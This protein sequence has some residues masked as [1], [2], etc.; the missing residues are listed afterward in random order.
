MRLYEY[1]GKRMFEKAGITV[2]KGQ[3]IEREDSLDDLRVSFPV[4]VKAQVLQGGRGKAGLIKAATNIE[5]LQKESGEI[6]SRIGEREVILLEEQMKPDSEAYIGI[7]VNDVE[8]FSY[9]IISRTG[10]MDIEQIAKES[11]EKIVKLRLP[12]EGEFKY[13]E[14]LKAV[15]KAGFEGKLLPQ[16]ADI[17]YNLYRMY[18]DYELD[19]IEINPLLIV[20]DKVVAGDSKVITDDYVIEKYEEFNR[21]HQSRDQVE[22]ATKAIYVPLEGGS[23]GIISYGASSTMMTV[24][25]IAAMG[26]FPANFSD[27]AGGANAQNIYELSKLI[28]E[29]SDANPEV[30]VVLITLTLVAHSMKLSVDAI[31]KAVNEVKPKNLK[32]VA[33]VRAA[34]AAKKEMDVE[35]AKAAFTEAGI[36]WCDTLGDAIKTCIEEAK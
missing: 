11:P 12:V 2:P 36:L 33:N 17:A 35:G 15:K 16:A 28:L 26:G 7:A 22:A 6:F 10:G 19:L 25:S 34:G 13:Y 20:G 21:I 3:V 32:L 30:K 27:I 5:E 31:I 1:E 18:M 23:I 8:G 4:M 9:M 29:R 24:D 14:V